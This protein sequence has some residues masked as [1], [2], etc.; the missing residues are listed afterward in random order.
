VTRPSRSF[1]PFLALEGATLLSG[2]GNGVAMVAMPWLVLD[3]TGDPAAAGLVAGVTALPMLLASLFSGTVIDRI[4]RRRTSV[5]SDVLSAVSVAAIPV[6]AL[7]GELTFTWVLALAVLGSV[8]DPAGVTAREAMLP[9]VAAASRLP[10]ARVNGVH[11]AIWGLAFLIGPALGGLLIGVVGAVDALWVMFVGFG[12][13]A[14]LLAL[15]RIPGAGRPH[16]DDRPAMWAGTL[17]GLRFVWEDH[18]LRATTLY[19]SLFVMLTYPVLGV[20]LPVVYES[21]DAPERLGVLLMSFSVGSIVGALLYGAMG[22]RVSQRLALLLGMAGGAAAIGWFALDPSYGW[23]VA[24]A[25]V[26][27]VLAGPM[28]PV[29]NLMLQRRTPDGL[30]GRVMGVIVSVAYGIVPLGY[31]AAGALVSAVG[32]QATLWL[33]TA[34]GLVLLVVA[35]VDRRLRHMDAA[36]PAHPAHGGDADEADEAADQGAGKPVGR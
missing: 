31:L 34:L 17:E 18:V 7:L 11:E 21:Q 26:G 30:R 24:G 5:V 20:V 27:G 1:T 29:V 19:S 2:L 35:A 14:A 13:S 12:A 15:V 36:H 25:V 9:D 16:V 3:L 28:N 33:V 6:V 4:G 23:L 22:H 8:F 10:L 32:A